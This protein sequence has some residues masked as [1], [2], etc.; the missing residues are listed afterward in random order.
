MDS[1]RFNVHGFSVYRVQQRILY[2]HDTSGNVQ[3]AHES[4]GKS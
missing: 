3:L 1:Q 2:V 4:F